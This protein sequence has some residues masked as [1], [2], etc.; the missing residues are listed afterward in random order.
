MKTEMQQ[1]REHLLAGQEHLMVI[2]NAH[3]ERMM[4]CLGKMEAA[5][6]KVNLE[7]IESEAEHWDVL[8]EVAAVKSLGTT[9]KLH[10][11]RHLAAGK[12]G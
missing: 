5:D 3:H 2:L 11:D 8:K 7:E 9:K 6:L 4:A 12:C 1:M 10:R